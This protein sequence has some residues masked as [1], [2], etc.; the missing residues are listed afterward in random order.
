MQNFQE[1]LK[2]FTK[3]LQTRDVFKKLNIEERDPANYDLDYVSKIARSIHDYREGEESTRSIK[4]FIRRCFRG[5][6]E[7][8]TAISCLLEMVPNDIYGSVISGS[9]SLIMLVSPMR[10]Q[11][12]QLQPYI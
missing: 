3:T 7:N 8:Q 2:R 4:K 9:F 1:T 6:H 10:L 12:R 11:S 5:A